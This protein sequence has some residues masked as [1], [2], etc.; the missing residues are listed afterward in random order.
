MLYPT[1]NGVFAVG[2]QGTG[3][4]VLADFQLGKLALLKTPAG[5][6]GDPAYLE[7]IEFIDMGDDPASAI[8]ALASKQIDG[9]VSADPLQYDAMKALLGLRLYQIPTAETAVLRMKV[10]EKPFDD[11]RVRK[12]MRLALAVSVSPA[13]TPMSRQRRLITVRS[14]RWSRMSRQPRSCW[15]MP[16]IR[17]DST[18]QFTCLPTRNGTPPSARVRSSS[19]SRSASM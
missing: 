12:A 4:F 8:S 7:G 19:G 1:E 3:P 14:R 5:Y 13:T 16:A 6:W 10:T 18:R 2:S 17:T 11:P 9:L 15:W